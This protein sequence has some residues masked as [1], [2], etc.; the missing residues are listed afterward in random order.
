MSRPPSVSSQ[1]R[2]VSPSASASVAL[3][4]SAPASVA[5][6]LPA[7][8]QLLCLRCAK[9]AAEDPS[10]CCVFD[11]SKSEDCRRCHV[12]RR[13]CENVSTSRLYHFTLLTRVDPVLFGRSRP[14][15]AAVAA[16]SHLAPGFPRET[17]CPSRGYQSALSTYS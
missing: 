2:R 3:S 9:R 17:V 6:S 14:P 10:I 11:R 7:L 4:L 1:A 5:P 12:R 13:S 15:T 8:D 16:T